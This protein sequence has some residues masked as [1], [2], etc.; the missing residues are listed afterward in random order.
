MF[1]SKSS[2]SY[3]VPK[4]WNYLPN[5]VQKADTLCQF[6]SRLKTHLFNLAYT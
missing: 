6:K 4:I 3:L 5:I 2:F 1:W